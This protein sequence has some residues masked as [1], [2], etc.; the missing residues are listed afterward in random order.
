MEGIWTAQVANELIDDMLQVEQALKKAQEAVSTSTASTVM[1]SLDPNLLTFGA[2]GHSRSAD[3]QLMQSNSNE[4]ESGSRLFA[5]GAATGALV[6]AV[7]MTRVVK[8]EEEEDDESVG[9]SASELEALHRLQGALSSH[10]CCALVACVMPCMIG[11][12]RKRC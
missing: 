11:N 12:L 2:G 1:P 3:T 10:V 5:S 8:E 9:L 6:A 4:F 7:D